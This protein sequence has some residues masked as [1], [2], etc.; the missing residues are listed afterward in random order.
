MLFLHDDCTQAQSVLCNPHR[1]N[2]RVSGDNLYSEALLQIGRST[3]PGE[4]NDRSKHREQNGC[5]LVLKRENDRSHAV[6][7]TGRSESTEQ[8]A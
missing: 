7:R 5:L 3:Q 4:Q 8:A 6:K 2:G 1:Y